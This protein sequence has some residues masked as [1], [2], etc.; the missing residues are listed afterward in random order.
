[1]G[2]PAITN[3]TPF[4]SELLQQIDEDGRAQITPLIKATLQLD[5]RGALVLAEEQSTVNLTGEAW[6]DAEAPCY[7]LEPE[8]AFVKPATDVALVGHACAVGSRTTQ[9]QVTL[10][11]GPL[12]K[13]LRVTGE[14]VWRKTLSGINAS[15][16]LPFE[17]MPLSYER[18]YGG[19]DRSSRNPSQHHCDVRNPVGIGYRAKGAAFQDETPLPN[20]EDPR[21]LIS[22]YAGSCAPA[23]FGFTGPDWQPRAA[24]GGT[25]DAAWLAARSPFLPVDFQRAFFNAASDGLVANGF[26]RGDEPIQVS[27]TQPSGQPL[28]TRLPGVSAPTC[29][30]RMRSRGALQLQT[31][32]DTVIIDTDQRQVFLLWRA[33]L[34]VAQGLQDVAA[35]SI[36]C[37]QAWALQARAS[38][39]RVIPLQ[40]PA[41][42]FSER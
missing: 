42:P 16:A 36:S 27:G 28:T 2:H 11:V 21:Q 12:A 3:H 18:A 4:A 15:V 38:R 26:L 8:T 1:M 19:W 5:D 25:Y 13:T 31:V 34:A 33:S 39:G 20:I 32:L 17:R 9:M 24:L 14:R 10:R 22:S 37:P 29:R 6:S 35:V 7:K 30:V 41:R 23:G 40:A